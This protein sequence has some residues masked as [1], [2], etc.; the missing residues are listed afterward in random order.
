[1]KKIIAQVRQSYH[2]FLGHDLP[3]REIAIK[4][5]IPLPL[6][7]EKPPKF[8]EIAFLKKDMDDPDADINYFK[9]LQKNLRQLNRCKIGVVKRFLY[10]EGFIVAF[11]PLLLKQVRQH[12]GSAGIPDVGPR[13]DMLDTIVDILAQ[14]I[15]SYKSI[16]KTIYLG[17]NFQFARLKVQFDKSA[18]RILELLKFQQRVMGLRYQLLSEQSWLSINIVFHIMWSLGKSGMERIALESISANRREPFQTSLQDL[19]LTLQMVQRFNLPKWP[20]EWQFSFD[21]FDQTM[22]TLLQVTPDDGVKMTRHVTLSYCYDT[23]ATRFKRVEESG[24]RGPCVMIHWQHLQKKVMADYLQ[25]FHEK[26]HGSRVGVMEKFEVLSYIEGLA[27]VQLQLECIK[28]EEPLLSNDALDGQPCDLRIFVGFKDVY[29]FLHNLH[30]HADLEEV[31][32]RMVDSL[33]QRSAVL[34]EDHVATKASVWHLQYQDSQTIKLKTQETQFTTGLKIGSLIAYGFGNEGI[35]QPSLGVVARIFRP[36]SKT[37]FL[38]IDRVGQDS[39]PVL[40]TADQASFEEFDQH[41]KQVI[42]AILTTD[43]QGEMALLFPPQSSFV[44]KEVL[45]LKRVR[46]QQL[47]QLGKLQSVT[48]SYLNFKLRVLKQT[49]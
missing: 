38:D 49:F 20:V 11:Y 40:A 2:E 45:V 44:E 16:F 8:R 17:K 33:A 24:A 41:G 9:S 46:G 29:P 6:A 34:A 3:P 22:R 47:I 13:Q 27:L 48:K 28:L 14:L 23:L 12:L 26:G 15:D 37:V 19:F 43:A 25:F 39:E 5:Q 36:S 4:F 7:R 18:Y 1:M 31:G 35:Q 10:N 30:Y 32:T 42:Y 21:R